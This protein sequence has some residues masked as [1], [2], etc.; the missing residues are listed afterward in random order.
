MVDIPSSD[1]ISPTTSRQIQN[2][3]KAEAPS[4]RQAFRKISR[5]FERKE[6]ELAVKDQKIQALEA[7]IERLRPK[8]R[9]KIPNPNKRFIHLSEI[10]ATSQELR[11]I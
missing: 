10:L 5:V 11:D 4:I 3:N 1:P 6:I 7:E 9:R 2:L 8:K